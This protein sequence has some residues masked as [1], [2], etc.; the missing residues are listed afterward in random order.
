MPHLAGHVTVSPLPPP[1]PGP[2][3][4]VAVVG[5]INTAKGSGI[6]A[7]ML[8]LADAH[9]LPV[10]F[11]LFGNIDLLVESPRLHDNGPYEPERL[12]HLLTDRGCHAV[13]LPSIWPETHCYVLDEVV[14]LG[15]PVGV[16][17]IGAPAE[18]LRH[19]ANGF[20]VFPI[21]PEAALSALLHATGHGGAPSGGSPS[22][23][24][25]R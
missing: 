13:F 24:G 6:L 5:G 18:R 19:W 10:Q 8:R 1:V 12:P 23:F 3:A 20:I 15:L 16:F 11:E 21:A 9:R 14:G 22:M 17:D 7:A 2:V 25:R 4:R